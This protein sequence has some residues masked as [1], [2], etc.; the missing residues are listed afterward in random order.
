MIAEVRRP[1]HL[2]RRVPLGEVLGDGHDDAMGAVR[3][4]VLDL[5]LHIARLPGHAT[6]RGDELLDVDH[7]KVG[8]AGGLG[9]QAGRAAE[10]TARPA[11]ARLISNGRR[12]GP[13]L[14]LRQAIVCYVCESCESCCVNLDPDECWEV[15]EEWRLTGVDRALGVSGRVPVGVSELPKPRWRS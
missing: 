3:L 11:R 8:V 1:C 2:V 13:A 14:R 6:D 15:Q 12:R 7:R 4:D 5:A 9:V 10:R